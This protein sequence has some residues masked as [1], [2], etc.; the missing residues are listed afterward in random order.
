MIVSDMIW[1]P[2]SKLIEILEHEIDNDF[3]SR[4]VEDQE[5]SPS[6][7]LFWDLH[8]NKVWMDDLETM[9]GY[10]PFLSA[11][12]ASVLIQDYY[13]LLKGHNL[14]ILH[15]KKD[16]DFYDDHIPRLDHGVPGGAVLKFSTCYDYV[17]IK[18]PID[19]FSQFYDTFHLDITEKQ[20]KCFVTQKLVVLDYE[21][22]MS[23]AGL[24]SKE[25]FKTP[26]DV[27]AQKAELPAEPKKDPEVAPIIFLDKVITSSESLDNLSVRS[28]N[29]TYY[30]DSAKT[31]LAR[32]V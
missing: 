1:R 28:C 23:S 29:Q 24:A 32:S 16:V 2:K 27:I 4:I 9:Y 17:F 30:D 22:G 12:E 21:F 3:R 18:L 31:K 19:P 8:K 20:F 14:L 11:Y 5:I 6:A 15:F 10:S 13:G 7:Q 25:I 26:M